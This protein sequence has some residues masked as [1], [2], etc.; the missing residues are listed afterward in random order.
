MS[1]RFYEGISPAFEGEPLKGDI[2]IVSNDVV[3]EGLRSK[4][5]HQI[6]D[7]VFRFYGEKVNKINLYTLEHPDGYHVYDPIVM[8]K[9][10]HSCDPNMDC[11][12]LTCTFTARRE[13]NP[14]EYLT[15]D[16]NQT[17]SVLYRPFECSCGSAN[18][19][20][21]IYGREGN[22]VKEEVAEFYWA[23]A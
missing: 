4:K 16:Y 8:G 5:S 3:G 12:M 21:T 11:D 15:M 23:E 20:G 22:T 14:G 2:E 19:R 13:I 17:E 6:G 7:I 9:A 1:D 18:C 10:L